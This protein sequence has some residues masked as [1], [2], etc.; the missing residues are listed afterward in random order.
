[1]SADQPKLVLYGHAESP[2]SEKC[3]RGLAYKRLA[4]EMRISSGP[5]DVR[6]WSPE[7]GLLPVMRVDGELV[8]DSTN[9]LL[10]LDR[11]RPEPPLLSLDPFVAAQQR[12]LEEWADESFLWYWQKWFQLE[13]E[14]PP[15]ARGAWARLRRRLGGGRGA[16]LRRARAEI[17]K[18]LESRLD[19]LVSFLGGRSFFFGEQPSIADLTVHSMLVTIRRDRIPGSARL[20]ASRPALVELMQRVEDATGGPDQAPAANSAA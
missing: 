3:R 19:D 13:A 11:I 4:Y 9:I 6:R 15:A 7:T 17:T 8:S 14:A 18:G 10:A 1:M 12:N 2:F 5:E 16:E 20:L